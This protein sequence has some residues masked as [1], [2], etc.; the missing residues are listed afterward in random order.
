MHSNFWQILDTI[1][2]SGIHRKLTTV[3]DLTD[4]DNLVVRGGG[5]YLENCYIDTIHELVK[6][7]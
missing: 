4:K 3:G 7:K 2:A 1:L 6:N 5:R